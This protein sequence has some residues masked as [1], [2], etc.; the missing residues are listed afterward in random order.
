MAELEILC[1]LAQ[2][3]VIV[4]PIIDVSGSMCGER[5]GQVNDAMAEVPAQLADIND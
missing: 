4:I 2:T 5:I 3:E 1:D